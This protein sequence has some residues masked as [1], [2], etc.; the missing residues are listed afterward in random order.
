VTAPRDDGREVELKLLVPP[1]ALDRLLAHPL[2]APV[3]DARAVRTRTVYLD[4]PDRAALARGVAVRMRSAGRERILSV[5]SFGDGAAGGLA[6]REEREWPA[7]GRAPDP[8]R[9]AEA[10]LEDVA[11]RATELAPLFETDVR[12]RKALLRTSDGAAVEAALDEG[13]VRAGGRG[14]PVLELELELADGPVEALHAL[15]R[16]LNRAA[17]LRIAPES[18]A[19]RGLR[20]AGVPRP[21]DPRGEGPHLTPIAT[22]AEA[23]RHLMRSAS[24]SLVQARADG[25]TAAAAA[26]LERTAEALRLFAP[27][28]PSP[29]RAE[30][31]RRATAAARALSRPRRWTALLAA[32]EGDDGPGAPALRA[33][34]DFAAAAGGDLACRALADAD[35]TDLVLAVGGWVE[36]D[37]WRRGGGPAERGAAE[38]Q[39]APLR[40]LAGPRLDRRQAAVADA[41]ADPSDLRRAVRRLATAALLV[42]GAYPAPAYQ[43]WAAGIEP[44]AR[45]LD[46]RSAARLARKA[47]AGL[48]PDGTD[49]RGAALRADR[50]LA[51]AARAADDALPALRRAAAA[52]PPFWTGAR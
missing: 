22:V 27:A 11:R 14:E 8:A 49:A 23:F 21:A 34:A 26:A 39:G 50:R 20:L 3:R 36:G 10:G 17:P 12:R 33:A 13:A 6:V 42:R 44:L 28:S 37:L 15:A 18:K 46:E 29:E 41:G 40:T 30:L 35:L 16:E 51:D 25:D 43:A 48:K 31:R 7:D 1:E 52:A 5:K 38:L 19:D 47:L 32:L 9:L 4:T 45:A 24:Q 2:L